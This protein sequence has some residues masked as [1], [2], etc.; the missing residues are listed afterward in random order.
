MLVAMATL[1]TVAVHLSVCRAG[2]L[3]KALRHVRRTSTATAAPAR[4]PAQVG[5]LLGFNT[6]HVVLLIPIAAAAMLVFLHFFVEYVGTFLILVA[7]ATGLVSVPYALH[8]VVAPC[9]P[10]SAKKAVLISISVVA[11]VGW[12]VSGNFVFNDVIAISLCIL[13]TS[14]VHVGSLKLL[15][16]L[17]VGLLVYDVVFVFLSP[18]LFGTN[19]MLEV[20]SVAPRNPLDAVAEVLQL[21][22]GPVKS[23]SFPGKLVLPVGGSASSGNCILGLGDVLLPSIYCSYLE[24]ADSALRLRPSHRTRYY[25]YTLP[26]MFSA[27]LLSFFFNV[28]FGAAQPALLYIVPLLLVSTFISAFAKG[29]LNTLWSGD[30]D[31][32]RPNDEEALQEL[33]LMREPALETSQ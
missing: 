13:I 21:S 26:V 33:L 12:L 25:S 31:T 19:V 6:G 32:V 28:H 23:L 5:D 8:P 14:F 29:D 11:V 15:T 27:V 10:T 17:L 4:V 18:Y 2:R 1:A 9:V 20:A 16:T 24:R 30:F 3:Q 22:A 7:A